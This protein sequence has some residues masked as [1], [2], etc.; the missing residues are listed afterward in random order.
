MK[1]EIKKD[2]NSKKLTIG[3]SILF[4]T[5]VLII[6]GTTAFFTQSGTDNIGNILTTDIEGTL[7]YND[8]YEENSLYNRQGLIP[9]SLEVMLKTYNRTDGN[10]CLDQSG[11]SSCSIYRFSVKNN[12]NVSQELT[13]NLNPTANSYNNLKFILFEIKNNN[14]EQISKNPISLL[15]GNYDSIQLVDNF[16]LTPNEERMYELVFYVENQDYAQDDAGKEFGAGISINSVTTGFN[17]TK[18]YGTTCWVVDPKDSSKLISFNGIN[19][20]ASIT[21]FKESVVESCSGYVE[22]DEEGFIVTI[23]STFNNVEIKSLG[24]NLLDA[25]VRDENGIPIGLNKYANIKKITIQ[26]GIERIEDGLLENYEGTFFGIGGDLINKKADPS[27][28]LE[29]KLPNSL[30][31]IG[32]VAFMASALREINIPERV[33]IIGE[34]TFHVAS[35]L[36]KVNFETV[37]DEH[38]DKVSAL[39]TIDVG[40]FWRCN[41]TYKHENPLFIPANVTT[42]EEPAFK[43]NPLLE[44]VYY[45]GPVTG[46]SWYDN[47]ITTRYP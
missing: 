15:K 16:M 34:F 4:C 33:E 44:A 18:Q 26:E 20:D 10:K 8:D 36:T 1:Y 32:D 47:N 28:T 35:N 37:L 17:V 30:K 25:I 19:H 2:N 45:E 43:E 23:P 27:K 24:N 22:V 5:I 40:A 9:A 46:S 42:I 12:S 21:D 11:Y 13:M 41:L 29:V 7:L 3:I 6:G 38:G 31:Y 39:R 14:P